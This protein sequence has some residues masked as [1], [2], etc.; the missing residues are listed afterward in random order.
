[1]IRDN[2]EQGRGDTQDLGKSLPWWKWSWEHGPSTD[3]GGAGLFLVVILGHG[4][5]GK[6]RG[7]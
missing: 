6:D 5:P 3:P 7:T 4:Q 1:M 2:W